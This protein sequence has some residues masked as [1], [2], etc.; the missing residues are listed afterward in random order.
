MN[1]NH[2]KMI[3]PDGFECYYVSSQE[4]TRYIYNEVFTEQQYIQNG[5][6]VNEGDCIFDVGA[7]IGMFSMFVN[8]LK[9]NLKTY[10]FEPIPSTFEVLKSN[11]ELH[12]LKDNLF[13]F[14]YGISADDN[15]EKVFTF[16]PQMA[17]NSTS[18]PLEKFVNLQKNESADVDEGDLFKDFFTQ[19]EDIKCK[20]RTLSS[21]IEELRIE[22]IDLL[23]IDVEGE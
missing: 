7:N 3:F 16:Y 4:E 10:A 23:K 5:I 12:S 11:V 6:V 9:R 22:C 14:N 19:V 15:T 2:Q 17:G 20:L 13:V 18:K 1:L 8:Q 21:V